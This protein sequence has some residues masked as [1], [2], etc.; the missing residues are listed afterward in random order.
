MLRGRTAEELVAAAALNRSAL[1]RFAAAIDAADQ[2]IKVEIAAY[3]SSIGIDVPHEAHTWPAKR[4]LRLAMGRQGKARKRRNPIMRDDAFRCIHC[5]ADVAAG[6][7]TVR[8][9]CP[10]CLRSV[11]VDVVPGDR[12]AGCNG[13]M[14]PV[15]LSRSHGDDTIQYRCARCVAAHQV[16]VHPDDDPAA[17]RA[18]VNLP[19]I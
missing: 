19:P 1:K 12:S 13:V 6:G 4:I 8:D 11:H 15:G 2:H 9:H 3:A 16:I 14:H 17:L 18:V 5:G 10:H 7:R